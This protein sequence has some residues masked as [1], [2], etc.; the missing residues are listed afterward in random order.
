MRGDQ[1]VVSAASWIVRASIAASVANPDTAVSRLRRCGLR[2]APRGE[3]PR[4]RRSGACPR[5][6]GVATSP[7]GRPWRPW[8]ERANLA[9]MLMQLSMAEGIPGA[10]HTRCR[11]RPAHAHRSPGHRRGAR[12]RRRRGRASGCPACTTSRCGRRCATR[13]S[14]SSACATS[15]PPPTPPTATRGR[16]ARSA[17]RSRR[18]GPGAAN[19]LGAVGE[20]WA[21]RSPILVI[22][23]DIPTDAA[24]PRRLPRRRCTRPTGQADD[25]RARWRRSSRAAPRRPSSAR[26]PRSTLRA[27]RR[28]GLPRGPDRPAVGDRREHAARRAARD[29]PA[30]TAP[31]AAPT[32]C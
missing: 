9:I 16:R 19:T 6:S 4:A 20:A 14:G 10:R 27:A 22:A 1:P 31:T 28:P 21:S 17:S 25:V 11:E 8:R 7:A 12:G 2:R 24:P 18:P 5:G 29:A 3:L 26:P 13:R 23:T 15:R 32:P 30:S